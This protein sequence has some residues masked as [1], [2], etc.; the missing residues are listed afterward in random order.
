LLATPSRGAG[1]LADTVPLY[2][3]VN[4]DTLVSLDDKARKELKITKEQSAAISKVLAKQREHEGGDPDKI[5]KM[6]GPDKEAKIRAHYK[7]RA[8]EHFK[9]LE[10]ALSPGQIKRLKQIMCQQHGIV[11]LDFPEIQ[12]A[13]GLSAAQVT[14]LRAVYDK[15]EKDL[16]DQVRA[17]KITKEEAAVDPTSFTRA[18]RTGSERK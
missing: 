5:F 8:D 15:L 7:T 2:T 16:I 9:V 11:L 4:I 3:A 10:Q 17:K 6:K 12:S 13:L 14:K 1:K 18:F